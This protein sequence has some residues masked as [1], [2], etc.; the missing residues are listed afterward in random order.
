MAHAPPS[1]SPSPRAAA[2]ALYV[3]TVL[4]VTMVL[5]PPFTSLNGTE[6]AFL[7][8]GPE[9]ARL[10]G[11][12][13]SD[14]GLATRPHWILLSVQLATVWAI[15]LGAQWFLGGQRAKAKQ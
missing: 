10:M 2:F 12:I 9:W 3:A 8:T 14:L 1:S 6:Y 15:A 11:S 4:T 5:F 13:D 7:L